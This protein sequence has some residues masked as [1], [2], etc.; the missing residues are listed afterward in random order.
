MADVD[1]TPR[2]RCDNCGETAEKTVQ[3]AHSS[4]SFHKPRAWGNMKAED[5][6]VIQQAYGHGKD[7]LDFTDLCPRCAMAAFKAASDALEKARGEGFDG[8]TGAE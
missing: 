5:G 6:R 1:I 8:P 3:G 4:R 7:R 2:I